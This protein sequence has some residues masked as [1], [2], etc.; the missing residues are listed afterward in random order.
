M[1]KWV[2]KY[3]V[4]PIIL[5]WVGAIGGIIFN[6]KFMAQIGICT[7]GDYLCTAKYGSIFILCLILVILLILVVIEIVKAAFKVRQDVEI[8][9]PEPSA[10]STGKIG[11]TVKNND[12]KNDL[13]DCLGR[14]ENLWA[15]FI[16]ESDNHVELIPPYP[17]RW[18]A[19]KLCWASQTSSD[20]NVTVGS[21][22]REI[23]DIIEVGQ[24]RFCFLFHGDTIQ[25]DCDTRETS[26]QE[27][28]YLL[29][30]KLFGRIDGKRIVITKC[31]SVSLMV[32]LNFV[33]NK[34]SPTLTMK[35]I[36]LALLQ[37]VLKRRQKRTTKIGIPSPKE[38]IVLDKDD[39]LMLN[40][41]T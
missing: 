4:L 32:M 34:P 23:L 40:T 27:G 15:V 31:Y 16:S 1:T 10:F 30:I 5:L 24:R 11:V 13:I 3:L 37:N 7:S 12:L 29:E 41:A 8:T 22:D 18:Y 2:L 17:I 39:F 26:L 33:D 36:N 35:E 6:E 9:L 20:G 25:L 28:D 14:I 38:I 21:N 19:Q